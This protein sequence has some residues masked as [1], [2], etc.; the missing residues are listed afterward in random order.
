MTDTPRPVAVYL[1]VSTEDQREKGTIATQRAEV[2]R[3]LAAFGMAVFDW[4]ADEGVTGTLAVDQRPEGKRLLADAERGC[5]SQVLVW[6]L[7]RLGRSPQVVLNVVTR[8]EAA[9]VAVKSTTESFDTTTPAGR[10][11]LTML[12]GMAGWERDSIVERAVAGMHRRARAGG[13][14]CGALPYGYM[15]EGTGADARIVVYDPEAE[16]VRMIFRWCIEDGW[17]SRRIAEQLTALGVPP[18]VDTPQ[19]GK[20][21]KKVASRWLHDRITKFIHAPAYKGNFKYGDIDRPCPPLVSEEVWDAAQVAL[22]QHRFL[23]ARSGN[24]QY[25]LRGLITCGVCGLNYIGSTGSQ[26]RYGHHYYRCS[27]TIRLDRGKFGREGKHCPSKSVRA[28]HLDAL[29]WADI[30]GFLRDPGPLLQELAKQG[31]ADRADAA[32]LAGDL[33]RYHAAK[34]AKDGERETVIALYRRGRISQADLDKQL[35][36]IQGEEATLKAQIEALEDRLS[37]AKTAER[38]VSDA[39]DLLARMR[40]LLAQPITWELQRQCVEAFVER[41]VIETHPNPEGKGRGGKTR[42]VV[43]ITYRFT[44]RPALDYDS[45]VSAMEGRPRQP[46][47]RARAPHHAA[48]RPLAAA[49]HQA[50]T[51]R[52]VAASWQF[53]AR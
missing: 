34:E 19:W 15:V 23:N 28:D 25:L 6:R 13:L 17:S 44:E 33:A 42:A 35:D 36:A 12:A 50:H 37:G 51:L 11:M 22:R 43:K 53:L 16:V 21:A 1:R 18:Y 10:L 20:R 14:V 38:K 32:S 39:A 2:E 48:H 30:E 26:A 5:F 46:R 41:V 9:G 52:A 47:A 31:S 4:Y 49:P 29:V 27:A 8:L 3:Y 24:H 40:P 7:D 45:A